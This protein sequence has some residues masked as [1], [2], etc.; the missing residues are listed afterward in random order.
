MRR[1]VEDVSS[2]EDEISYK[3]KFEK[4]IGHV[5]TLQKNLE[6]ERMRTK[7]VDAL[8]ACLQ[9]EREQNQELKDKLRQKEKGITV[10]QSRLERLGA[11][12][13]LTLSDGEIIRPGTSKSLLESVMAENSRLKQNQKFLNVDP[14]RMEQAL[15][16]KE[17]LKQEIKQVQDALTSVQNRLSAAQTQLQESE[18]EKDLRIIKLEDHVSEL[19]RNK[20]TQS[21]L[22][23]SL[24][25]ETVSLRQQLKDTMR[26][27]QDTMR[28]LEI[29]ED[30]GRSGSAGGRS[31]DM[32]LLAQTQA[33]L[34]QLQEELSARDAKLKEVTDMNTRWQT[35]N[36]QRDQYTAELKAK[37]AGQVTSSES[38][39]QHLRTV[40]Q[41]KQ[42]MEA[43]RQQNWQLEE[44]NRQLKQKLE[45]IQ[46]STLDHEKIQVYEAQIRLITEDFKQERDDRAREHDRAEELSKELAET[47]AKLEEMKREQM[48]SFAERRQRS[49]ENAE[50]QYY[51]QNMHRGSL[52]NIGS[53]QAAFVPRNMPRYECDYEEDELNRSGEQRSEDVVDTP[54][55]DVLNCP[56]CD[57]S[58]PMEKHAELLEHLD[59]CE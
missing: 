16:E 22:C 38:N 43:L 28:R 41:L 14:A 49:L 15:R 5:N 11:N 50:M 55:D 56:K 35:Y 40:N 51:Q 2:S 33:Q 3:N 18:S 12:S 59:K 20:D 19:Q 7:G 52:R 10:L 34:Q 8:S 31:R 58:Y 24:S 25:E 26:Q 17:Q 32:E 21:V 54:S 44:E 48:Q 37:L 36:K 29:N 45:T 47:K 13:S 57:K 23:H 1:S 6:S 27:M 9:E 30:K 46:L 53:P 42:Q 39:E 4:L